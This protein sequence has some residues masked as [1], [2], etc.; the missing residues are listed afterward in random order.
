M[1]LNDL[2]N[3]GFHNDNLKMFDQAWGETLTALVVIWMKVSLENLSERQVRGSTLMKNAL[4]LS[5]W[6]CSEN[7][8]EELPE[9][10]VNDINNR[11]C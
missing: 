11:T 10:V 9:I 7:G 2:L 8:A 4:T 1:N 5:V 3:V 6:H